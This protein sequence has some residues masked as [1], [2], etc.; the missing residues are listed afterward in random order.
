M[1]KKYQKDYNPAFLIMGLKISFFN[2]THLLKIPKNYH[3]LSIHEKN[4][5]ES[6]HFYKDRGGAN[7]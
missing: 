3:T 2:E 1:S 5:L 7:V 4:I 6:N